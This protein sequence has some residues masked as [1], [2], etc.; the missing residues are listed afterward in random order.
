MK[1]VIVRVIGFLNGLIMRVFVWASDVKANPAM[2]PTLKEYVEPDSSVTPLLI[3]AAIERCAKRHQ[4]EPER[5]QATLNAC[6]T[7]L[8][9]EALMQNFAS[10]QS[11][12]LAEGLPVGEVALRM[13]ANVL[14]IGMEIGAGG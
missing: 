3:M 5:E 14:R 9:S 11:S 7:S 8:R 6:L 12:L 1:T 2:F 4:D 10:F 13:M